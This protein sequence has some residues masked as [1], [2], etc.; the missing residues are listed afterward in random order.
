MKTMVSKKNLLE[1][2]Q[3]VSKSTTKGT[4]DNIMK[5]VFIEAEGNSLILRGTDLDISIESIIEAEVIESGKILVDCK[6]LLEII[7]KLADGDISME[8]TENDLS[9]ICGKSNFTV[10]KMN[11]K[12][13]PAFPKLEEYSSTIK[14]NAE[15]LKQKIQAVSFAAAKDE[16]RPI[17]QGILFE[18]KQN[19]LTL[20]ALDGYRMSIS[21][22]DV[23][24]NS[25]C[26][27]VL[28]GTH[29]NV[30]NI[31]EKEIEISFS[32]NH[33]VFASENLKVICRLLEGNYVNYSALINVESKFNV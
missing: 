12:E 2:L 9:I 24:S 14:V 8:D 13:F 16:S 10:M 1:G 29:S 32:N 25:E 31:L 3:K 6:L 20:V 15:T 4:L 5:G 23:E 21:K 30:V 18:L 26:S 22:V 33:I 28:N 19:T 17:L 27:C 11:E 7:R